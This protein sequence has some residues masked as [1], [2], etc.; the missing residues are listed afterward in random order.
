MRVYIYT[1]VCVPVFSVFVR[2]DIIYSCPESEKN[3]HNFLFCSGVK[4]IAF[5]VSAYHV[6]IYIGLKAKTK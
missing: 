3:I 1:C 6:A 2:P 4:C 5:A